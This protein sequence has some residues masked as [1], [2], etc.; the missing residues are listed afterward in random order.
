LFFQE[1]HDS[2]AMMPD[3]LTNPITSKC[4]IKFGSRTLRASACRRPW[5]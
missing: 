5:L 1:V 3:L 2:N 4:E